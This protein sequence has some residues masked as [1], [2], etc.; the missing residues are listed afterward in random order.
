[1]HG[2]NRSYCNQQNHIQAKALTELSSE[3]RSVLLSM[4]NHDWQISSNLPLLIHSIL[5]N[6]LLNH[7][8]PIA[9]TSFIHLQCLEGNLLS[10]MQTRS[11]DTLQ[12][13]HEFTLQRI[14]VRIRP[15]PMLLERLCNAHFKVQTSTAYLPCDLCT[16]KG[17]ELG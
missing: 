8:N 16:R 14:I 15:S 5:H 7:S 6:P 9:P 13:F 2:E 17:L 10:F 11:L 3:L 4:S 12:L 1:M